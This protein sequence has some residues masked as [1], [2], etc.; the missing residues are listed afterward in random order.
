MN[1][2][3]PTG[4]LIGP[5]SELFGQMWTLA[6]LGLWSAGLWMLHLVLVISDQLLTPDLREDG[7][8][9]EVYR[10]T[11]WLAG[12][13]AVVML[14]VQIGVALLRRDAQSLG[15]ALWGCGKF[16]VVWAAWLAYGAAVIAACGGLT[17]ALLDDLLRVR[18]WS[19]WQPG[20]GLRPETVVDATVATALGLLGMV[21]W[22]AAVGHAG[23]MV[24]RAATLL[25]LAAVTPIAAAGLLGEV[26]RSWF[27]KSVRWF[28]AAALTP[29]LV[30]LLIGVGVQVTGGV[31]A[32]LAAGPARAVGTAVPGVLLVAASCFAPLALFRLLAFVEP[33][34]PAG[35][36][37][38][39]AL[40]TVLQ[41]QSLITQLAPSP[42]GSDP[43]GLSGRGDDPAGRRRTDAQEQLDATLGPGDDAF[44]AAHPPSMPAPPPPAGSPAGAAGPPPTAPGGSRD[45]GPPGSPAVSLEEAVPPSGSGSAPLRPPTGAS[46]AAGSTGGSSAAATVVPVV[47]A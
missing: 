10:V 14:L 39:Q 27:W 43:S 37:V 9:S 32:G 40:S 28:H 18:R 31:A 34:T 46:G 44:R 45:A 22:L 33:A 47:P 8:A 29:V 24:T 11:F 38:R 13:L 25:V 26:G 3:V 7:P 5:A 2:P 1:P 17:R 21:L 35:N 30:A 41:A 36:Q 15:A 19:E 12:A 42:Q 4:P 16:V 6:M 20:L 23:L